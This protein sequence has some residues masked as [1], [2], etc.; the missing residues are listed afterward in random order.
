MYVFPELNGI[1]QAGLSCNASYTAW[2][3]SD[4]GKKGGEGERERER[5]RE[6]IILVVYI[7]CYMYVLWI[8]VQLFVSIPLILFAN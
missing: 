6:M 1:L 7:Q 2:W 4:C 8:T 5:E 3:L